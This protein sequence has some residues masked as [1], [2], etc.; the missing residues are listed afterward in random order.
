MNGRW[1]N[2]DR[3]FSPGWTSD[4]HR[5]V[6]VP[7]ASPR[8]QKSR[9]LVCC[10]TKKKKKKNVDL[11]LEDPDHDQESAP[12]SCILP[13]EFIQR[14]SE[15]KKN[16]WQ[17]KGGSSVTMERSLVPSSQVI[18]CYGKAIT[19]SSRGAAVEASRASFSAGYGEP[20]SS[21]VAVLAAMGG[22]ERK[23]IGAFFPGNNT[24]YI[25][26]A[27]E[28]L[29][30]FTRPLRQLLIRAQTFQGE[31]C[32]PHNQ[33]ALVRGSARVLGPSTSAYRKEYRR[34]VQKCSIFF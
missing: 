18:G 2:A 24:Q 7:V 3:F 13:V 6:I 30:K 5:L 28:A 4:K 26:R 20:S 15:K 17:E 27:A 22:R 1:D 33:P 14:I 23:E 12:R 31:G 32:S 19:C 34:T 29:K 21:D 11:N 25:G 9:I 8:V 10:W 16:Y